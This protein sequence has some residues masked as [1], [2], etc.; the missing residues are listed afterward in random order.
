M[1]RHLAL[2]HLGR[3]KVNADHVGDLTSPVR[4]TTPR[5]TRTFALP[6]AMD[7]LFAQLPNRQRIDGGVNRLTTDVGVFKL[8]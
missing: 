7:E 8:G 4:L 2:V 5:L 3:T 6:Q 1:P